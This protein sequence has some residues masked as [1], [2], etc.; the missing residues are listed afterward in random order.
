[1]CF[2]YSCSLVLV[3]DWLSLVEILVIWLRFCFGY[4]GLVCL[5]SVLVKIF[6]YLVKICVLVMLDWFACGMCFG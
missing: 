6:G 2:G 5:W 3:E 4:V 1:M